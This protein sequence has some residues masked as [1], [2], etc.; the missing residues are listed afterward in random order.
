MKMQGPFLRLRPRVQLLGAPDS[1]NEQVAGLQDGFWVP[2]ACRG[3]RWPQGHQPGPPTALEVTGLQ[4]WQLRET[5]PP[6]TYVLVP[7]H[8][9]GQQGQL[10]YPG[11]YSARQEKVSFG[12]VPQGSASLQDRS[13]LAHQ[14]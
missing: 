6:G 5:H 13:I 4:D 12:A 3:V 7:G 2:W 8:S 11:I 14:T 1:P 9:G 10:F